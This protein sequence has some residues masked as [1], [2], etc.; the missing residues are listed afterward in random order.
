MQGVSAHMTA[1]LNLSEVL[2]LIANQAAHLVHAD[3]ST[4]YV[5]NPEAGVLEQIAHYNLRNPL[6][7]IYEAKIGPRAALDIEHST[8]AQSVM[9]GIPVTLDPESDLHLGLGIPA[10][11]YRSMFCVPLVAPRGIMGAICLYDRTDRVFSEEQIHLLDAFGHEAAVAIENSRLYEAALT[12]LQIKSAML[13]EMNHRVRNNLQTVAGLLS[14]RSRRLNPEGEAASA[15][16]ESIARI[17]S[18]AA[19]HDLMMGSDVLS[20]SLYEIARRVAEAAVS[21]LVKPGFDLLLTIEPDEAENIR[22]DSQKATLMALLL[23]ELISNAILHGFAG[24]DKGELSIRAWT[25]KGVEGT[26]SEQTAR[27]RPPVVNFEVRDDGLG[28]PEGFDVERTANLGLSI[29]RTMVNSDLRGCF[30][31]G[32]GEGGTGTRTSIG[33]RT[34]DVL[35]VVL[36]LRPSVLTQ[37]AN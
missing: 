21:T 36:E 26:E 37:L 15:L 25:D 14:M 32:P 2:S 1:T 30:T 18:I 5:I 12:G 20:T 4:I 28:L 7:N 16:R 3:A 10:S 9:K 27:R 33:L 19:V 8:I 17:Q 6:H 34:P 22:I 23:N 11:E 24:L 13:Q 35:H 31:I 29:V